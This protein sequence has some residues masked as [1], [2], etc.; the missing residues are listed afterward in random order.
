MLISASLVKL[1]LCLNILHCSIYQSQALFDWLF[2]GKS[3]TN[4][5]GNLVVK[6]SGLKFEVLTADEKFLQLKDVIESL[7]EQDSCNHVVRSLNAC[8]FLKLSSDI[9]EQKS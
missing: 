5:D 8:M 3:E 2:G 4:A 6:G 9:Y 1:I 7:S